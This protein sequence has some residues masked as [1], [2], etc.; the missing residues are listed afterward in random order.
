MKPVCE[1][2]NFHKD[3]GLWSQCYTYL[4]HLSK[5]R[6]IAEVIA[7]EYNLPTNL[8]KI[9]SNEGVQPKVQNNAIL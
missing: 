7:V 4:D 8:I 1:T 9:N 6:E 3:A 2:A 5:Q